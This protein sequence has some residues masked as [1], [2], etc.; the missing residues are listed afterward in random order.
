MIHGFGATGSVFYTL[1][2]YLRSYFRIT[3]IDL[4]GLGASG[5]PPT[6]LPTEAKQCYDYYL[7]AIQAWARETDYDA[8]EFHLLGHSLGGHLSVLYSIRY[9]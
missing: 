6:F 8:E 2:K 4:L 7:M 9:P 1:V 3:T 5:R